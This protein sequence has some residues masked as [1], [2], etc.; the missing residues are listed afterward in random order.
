MRIGHHPSSQRFAF[1]LACTL[2]A[3][4]TYGPPT[5]RRVIAGAVS[6][7]DT[8]RFGVIVRTDVFRSPT[9]LAKFPD[10]G[11][12][13]KLDQFVT[14]FAGD[15][16]SGVVYTLGKLPAPKEVWT[17]FEATLLGL[18]KD[19]VYAVLTGC[20]NT[21][22]GTATPTR[23]F[24]RFG[25]DGAVERLKE[26]PVDVE[27]QPAM[28]ARSPGENVY[29]RVGTHGDSITAVTVD[30]G[31]FVAR[32]VLDSAGVVRPLPLRTKR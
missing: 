9:G 25:F 22:C 18:K 10:G 28:I 21:D 20:P 13:K 11:A 15:V 16:D 32:F 23:I 7:T 5:T 26:R 30:N 2:I 1:A 29:T 31:P 3:G 14:A 12:E 4:C 24:F 6:R 19:G 17:G 27:R 8:R